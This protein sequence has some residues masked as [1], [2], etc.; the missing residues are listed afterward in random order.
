MSSQGTEKGLR[1]IGG[2]LWA[3]GM[4]TGF[5]LLIVLFVIPPMSKDNAVEIY[6][7]M[8][9]G[10]LFAVPACLLYMLVPIV[11]DRYDPEPWWA[12][13]LVFGWGAIAACGFA[14]PINTIMGE[15]GGALLGKSGNAIF[16]AVISAPIVEE[17]FKGIAILG[18]VIF[19]RREFDGVV[20]GVIYATFSALGFAAVEN[21]IYYSRGGMEAGM[22]GMASTFF[23]R[24]ILTPWLHPL[25]TAMTGIGF[26]ITRESTN[27]LVKIIAPIGGY[28]FAVMLHA[29]WNGTSVFFGCGALLLL[30]LWFLFLA[31]FGALVIYLVYREGKIIRAHLRDEVLLG[32]MT[33]QE[34]EL[35]CS[36]V[37]RLRGLLTGGRK[38]RRFVDVASRLG[39]SKW[40]SSRAA[41]GQKHTV[42]M[43]F[44]VPL[45]QELAQLRA[46]MRHLRFIGYRITKRQGF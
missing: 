34:L 1:V 29:T 21:I 6:E 14:A 11:L 31:M 22:S 12:L 9:M 44:I 4:L 26:G 17:F 18:V 46:E 41:K 32:A 3:M 13:A 40:H 43:D 10:A 5:I 45:R 42:S 16:G 27:G 33:Q 2:L 15:I 25:F 19:L 8:A 36:P 35:V 24:G 7:M 23:I 38:G 39:L 28:M 20:D 37:G 30:P